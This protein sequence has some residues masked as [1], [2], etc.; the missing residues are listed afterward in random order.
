M[1]PRTHAVALRR[2]ALLAGA[3]V[4]TGCGAADAGGSG[5]D[6]LPSGYT[7]T[8]CTE[9]TAARE[10]ID[11][12]SVSLRRPSGTS[13]GLTVHASLARAP[14]TGQGVLDLAVGLFSNAGTP[15]AVLSARLGPG[16]A[17]LVFYDPDSGQERAL[18]GRATITGGTVA[19]T[20][21]VD[22]GAVAGEHWQWQA[23]IEVDGSSADACPS[24]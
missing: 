18:P 21:P 6:G 8:S 19:V 2:G 12:S 13:R 11:L 23:S 5:A 10:P 3:L 7:A 14:A 15:R 16:P 24:S 9:P 22:P 4:L 1:D 17:R 20:F